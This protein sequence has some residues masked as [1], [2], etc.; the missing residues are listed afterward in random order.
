MSVELA[1]A[2]ILA[3]IMIYIFLINIYSILFR[4]TGLTKVKARFQAISLLTN[5]GYTTSES[6]IVTTNH[7][8][9]NIAI[10]SMMTGYIFSV[11]IVSLV[12]NLINAVSINTSK[13]SYSY[14]FIAFGVFVFV[15][16]LFKIPFIRR[17]FEKLIELFGKSLLGKHKKTNI[18]TLLDSYGRE[19]IAQVTL[20]YVPI[21]MK[22]KQLSD[23]NIRDE[24]N[25][26][27]LMIKTSEGTENITKMTV[28][29]E[30]DIVIVFGPLQNIKKLF[31]GK[32][33]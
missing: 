4:I 25:L 8:R 2:L 14:I 16:L 21:I 6:E 11:V 1:I 33:E 28:L 19:A 29:K 13:I 32:E 23:I 26:N 31:L 3:F 30:N 7:L 5:S 15:I 18:I 10:A 24:Y 17:P 9:R 22:D 20:N 12:L 27:I